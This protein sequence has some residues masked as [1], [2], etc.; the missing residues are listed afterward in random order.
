M[1]QASRWIAFVIVLLVTESAAAGA[2]PTPAS[3]YADDLLVPM[4]SEARVDVW[5]T[6]TIFSL[7]ER[8]VGGGIVRF[9]SIGHAPGRAMTGGDGRARWVVPDL[10]EG[11]HFYR[12]ESLGQDHL[13]GANC[14]VTVA[15]WPIDSPILFVDLNTILPRDSERGLGPLVH[16]TADWA[17]PRGSV[18]SLRTLSRRFRIVYLAARRAAEIEDLRGS[19]QRYGYP[20]GPILR[21]EM[22]IGPGSLEEG[23]SGRLKEIREAGWS[24]LVAGVGGTLD[25]A[26]AFTHHGIK[27][28]ILSEEVEK[29][30]LPAGARK[31]PSWESLATALKNLDAR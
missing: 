20:A 3:L 5:L 15:V 30:D 6:E 22:G 21:L 13:K 12:A 26:L 19:M 11:I 31:S 9:T 25:D 16:R 1:I 27:V 28:V 29:E 18:Q 2:G 17:P 4:G 24:R 8:P 23:I 7:W 14:H 10:P